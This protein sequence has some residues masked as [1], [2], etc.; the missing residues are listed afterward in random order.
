M[1]ETSEQHE[2]QLRDRRGGGSAHL[3]NARGGH[4]EEK[5]RDVE[6]LGGLDVLPPD[7]SEVGLLVVVSSRDV[8]DERAVSARHEHGARARG[9]AR[10]LEVLDDG[11]AL[12]GLRA[13][14][15]AKPESSGV[16]N[17]DSRL[18]GHESTHSSWPTQ[19]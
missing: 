4:R 16:I 2:Q 8:G 5:S 18:K 14:C 1:K 13:E 15:F 6:D 9:G 10:V 17:D 19:L 3:D 7:F 12:L 11:S